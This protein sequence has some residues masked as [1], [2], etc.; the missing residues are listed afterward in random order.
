VF[1]I[2]VDNFSVMLSFLNQVTGHTAHKVWKNLV[3][4]LSIKQPKSGSFFRKEEKIF[5]AHQFS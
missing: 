2:L 5:Y 1:Y 3:Y 4:E